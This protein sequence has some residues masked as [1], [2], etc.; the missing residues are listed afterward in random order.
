MDAKKWNEVFAEDKLAYTEGLT[1]NWSA[2]AKQLQGPVASQRRGYYAN[3]LPEAV[4]RLFNS[5]DSQGDAI[6]SYEE[7]T[8]TGFK[9][10]QE[11][12]AYPSLEYI[13]NN[14]HNYCGGAGGFMTEHGPSAFDPIFWLHHA[15]VEIETISGILG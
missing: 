14:L 12:H 10:G 8:T 11:S 7:F 5:V 9:A 13:H 15:Y 6:M 2:I 3:T 4:Y 1:T